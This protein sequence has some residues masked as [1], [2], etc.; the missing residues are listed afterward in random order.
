MIRALLVDDEPPARKRLRRMLEAEGVAIIGEASNGLEALE[1][2]DA[3]KSELDA[4]FLDIE[5]PELDGMETARA[6]GPEG[7]L[8]VFVTA[9]DEFALQAFD[10]HAIDYLVKP[11]AAPRL[12]KALQKIRSR[13]TTQLSQ[14]LDEVATRRAPQRMAVKSGDRHIVIDLAR[15]AA[16]LA[17]DHYAAIQI[18]GRELL[19]DDPLDAQEKKLDPETF[20]RVHRSAI[21]N[22]SFVRELERE[23][24]RKYVA[25]LSDAAKTRVAIARDRLDEVKKRLGLK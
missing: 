16:I 22:L 19:A 21:V 23:G 11:V 8:I 18:D 10:T 25:V 6:I 12:E 5:M 14:A 9:Y 2:I 20:L 1:R 13:H 3:L 17:K 15:I 24:D 4:V 7:P